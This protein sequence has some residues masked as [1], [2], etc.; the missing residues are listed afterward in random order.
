MANKNL[1][2]PGVISKLGSFRSALKRRLFGEGFAWALIA[3]AGAIIATFALDFL[4]N[5][6]VP[7][8]V[9][10][11]VMAIAGLGYVLWTR[12]L[13]PLFVPMET[14]SLALLVEKH[15]D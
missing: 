12:L 10:F 3:L 15:F 7:L 5:L 14:E 4:L 1:V 8:R 11:M 6:P 9:V 2:K 13:A